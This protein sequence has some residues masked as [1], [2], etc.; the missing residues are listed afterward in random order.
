M[1]TR[2]RSNLL[3]Q[4]NL[5]VL[6]RFGQQQY[7]ASS[8][9]LVNS[10]QLPPAGG[11]IAIQTD[12]DDIVDDPDRKNRN[13]KEV[14]HTTRLL[15]RAGSNVD[16]YTVPPYKYVTTD[17][18]GNSAHWR[19]WG[20]YGDIFP[21][22]IQVNWDMSDHD[23]ILQAKHDFFQQNDVDTLLNAIEAPD[24]VSG[25]KSVYNRVNVPVY[26][27]TIPIKQLMRRSKNLLGFVS[28]GYLYYGF[29]IAPLVADMNKVSKAGASYSKRLKKTLETAGT[30]VSVHK[31]CAG[32]LSS[33]L[34]N[35]NGLPLPAAYAPSPDGSSSWH[36][37]VNA[38]FQ[39][40]KI[41]SIR[42]IR[43][44]KY[45]S[46]IFG[47]LDDLMTRFGSTGPAS[48]AWE[49]IPFSFVVDWFV[50]GSDVF[51]QLDNFLT[52]SRKKIVDA[53]ISYK[54]QCSAGAIKHVSGTT[55]SGVDG[56]QTAVN[57]LSYY[58]RKP[59]D[60][61]LSTGLSG[62]FGKRQIGLTAALLGQMATKLKL[63][64]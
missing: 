6:N 35:G 61:S 51:D 47:K 1:R 21:E 4:D 31:S 48:L 36:A 15:R 54:W 52:G 33:V 64:R 32:Q 57:E 13:A 29:G 43:N 9:A 37:A 11:V 27:R 46:P 45:S 16:T 38:T 40:K 28:G 58:Y 18:G 25:L 3:V 42:G 49:R 55:T 7:N 24:F 44:H 23:L 8:G 63:K 17:I 34:T 62:R 26:S 30:A 22:N 41:V 12:V 19:T 5:S 60:P 50:D 2:S 14:L 56:V 39:P 59:I 20:P 10:Y 53:T